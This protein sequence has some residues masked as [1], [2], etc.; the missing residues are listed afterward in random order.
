[1]ALVG[2]VGSGKST[3]IEGILGELPAVSSENPTAPDHPAVVSNLDE[4]RL[5]RRRRPGG[6]RRRVCY[7]AQRPWVMGGTV[8]D[9]VL[10]GMPMDEGRYRCLV[11]RV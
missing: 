6:V 11:P 2:E 8:R 10:F 1:M 4:E 9:N 7:A 5:V 3:L